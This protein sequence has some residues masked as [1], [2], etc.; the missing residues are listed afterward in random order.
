MELLDLYDD[1]GNKL[2]KIVERGEPI[3]EGNLM[4]VVCIIKNN[5]KEYL[6]NNK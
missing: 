4:L 2:N 1:K 5:N 3:E 6:E